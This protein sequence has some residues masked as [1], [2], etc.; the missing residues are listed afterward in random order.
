M[1]TSDPEYQ[2]HVVF[3]QLDRHVEFYGHLAHSVFQW[4]SQGTSAF[5][6]I[7]SYV[8]SSMQGTLASVRTILRDGRI[9]D[10]YA[11]LRK[12]FDSAI[13]NIYSMLYLDDHFSIDNFIVEQIE[14]WIKGT[15]QLPTYRVMSQ[16]IRSS[17]RVVAINGLLIAD[18]RYRSLRERCN[19]HT[20]YNFYR[21]ILFNDSE[22]LVRGRGKLLDQ[23]A[24]DVRDVFLLHIAYVLFLRQNYMMSSDFIDCLECGVTP[25]A[26]SQYLVAPYVQEVFDQTIAKHRPDVA[27]VI[28]EHTTMHLS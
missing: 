28:R 4:V 21:Y 12:Y 3:E 15:A 27:A 5:C 8:F 11:L 10:A 9:N 22:I 7:D 20:H 26:D 18:P 13:I 23:L 16:Y 1:L 25:D 2:N 24:N 14:G 17:P 19:D 6:N